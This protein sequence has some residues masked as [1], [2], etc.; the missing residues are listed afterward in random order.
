MSEGDLSAETKTVLTEDEMITVATDARDFNWV[1]ASELPWTE[2]VRDPVSQ[3]E[4]ATSN[5]RVYFSN[6]AEARKLFFEVVRDIARGDLKDAGE[7]KERL[8]EINK[9]SLTGNGGDSIY[10]TP[11][12][13]AAYQGRGGRRQQ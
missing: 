6:Q 11:T 13:M 7:F 12:T 1:K 3:P 10:I 9:V 8:A 2:L 5:E 4:P